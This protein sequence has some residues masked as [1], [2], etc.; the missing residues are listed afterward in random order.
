MPNKTKRPRKAADTL[1]YTNN[2]IRNKANRIKRAKNI[3]DRLG[4]KI[5]RATNRLRRLNRKYKDVAPDK[6][7]I[8]NKRIE[9][10]KFFLKSVNA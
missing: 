4:K 3:G 5:S 7:K 1:R 10:L 2:T 9:E 8:F 6:K